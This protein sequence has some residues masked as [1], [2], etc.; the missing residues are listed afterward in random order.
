[1]DNAASHT[2]CEN[3]INELGLNN[4]ELFYLPPNT[5][6]YVQPID[7]GIGRSFKAQYRKIFV[8]AQVAAYSKHQ[9]F[10][11]SL[12]DAIL[13]IRLAWIKVTPL[14]IQNC[15]AHA[16]VLPNEVPNGAHFER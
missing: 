6:A 16:K 11:F 14:V 15:W 3:E 10:S 5:T 1:M 8:R 13:R 2:I 4:V 12:R 9:L 7:Q